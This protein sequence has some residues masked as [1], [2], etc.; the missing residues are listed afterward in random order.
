MSF[1]QNY[2]TYFEPY[3]DCEEQKIYSLNE[4]MEAKIQ[5]YLQDKENQLNEIK[6]NYRRLADEE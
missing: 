3:E 2:G 5:Q 4:V 6:D 1:E